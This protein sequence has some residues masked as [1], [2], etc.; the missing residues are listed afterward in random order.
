MTANPVRAFSTSFLLVVGLVVPTLAQQEGQTPPGA[1]PSSPLIVEKDAAGVALRLE[2]GAP[3]HHTMNDVINERL[4]DVQGS[5]VRLVVWEEVSPTGS[6]TPFQAISLD[7]QN[8]M[9]VRPTSY[10]LKV[11]HSDFDPKAAVPPVDTALLADATTNMYIVQFVT[12]P[13]DEFRAAIKRLGGTVYY[14]IA[15]N[16]HLVKM[17]PAVRDK[18]ATLPYVRWVGHYHPAYRIEEYMRENRTR[19]AELF[20]LQRYNVQVFE[21]GMAQKEAVAGRIEKLGG[22]IDRT[23]AGKYLLEATL[24]PEQ[25]FEVIRW[26]EV[27]FVDRWS[28]YSED[29]DIVRSIGG[30]DYI[31]TVAGYTGQGVRGEAYDAGCNVNHPDFASRPLILHGSVGV[32]AHGTATAGVCF[33]DGAGDPQARGLMPDGQGI[34]ADYN[35]IGMGGTNRYDHAGELLE[36]PY[37]AV[38]QTS[39]VGSSQT[40]EYTTI[41]A[42]TDAMLFDFD[43][44]HC[45]SQSNMGSRSSRPQAW[46]K[47]IVSGGAVKHYNTPT[48]DDDCWCGGASIGPA[49]DGRI[50]P[51]LCFFYDDTYTTYS[52]GSGYGE[53]GGTSGATP[54]ICGHIGLF[55]QMWSDG[56]FNNEVYPVGTG[57]T[58]YDVFD[59]RPHMTLA[60]A[61]MINTASPYD[62]SGTGHDLTRVHQGWGLP[63]LQYIYDIRDKLSF[64]NETEILQNMES[65][66]YAAYVELGEPQLRVTLVYADPE[67]LPPSSQ[68]RINDLTLKVTSPSAEVYWGNWGLLEGN[69]SVPGG[70]PNQVDTVENVFVGF[71]ESGAWTV[72]I[73]ASEINGDGHVETPEWDA[74]FSLVVT[75]GLLVA[76][77]EIAFPEGVPVLLPPGQPTDITVQILEGDEEYVQDS[78]MLHYRYD[79]GA[80]A[81][82]P[83]APLGGDLY[84]AT[85]PAPACGDTPEF[86]FSAEGSESGVVY[87]PPDAPAATF[88]AD[89]GVYV[90]IM[91]DDFET[92]QG[93]TVEDA[94]GLT[95]GTWER[96][97]PIGSGDRQDPPTD[98][99]GSGQCYLTDNE[100]GNSDVDDGP[101]MLLSPTIDLS[102]AM[103]PVFTYAR[104][105]RNDDQDEDPMDVEISDDD[106][107][108]WTLIERVVYGEEDPVEDWVERT[109]HV[110]DYIMPLTS[111]MKI[112][113]SVKDVPNNSINEAGIDAIRFDD[114]YCGEVACNMRGDLTGDGTVDGA[115]IQAFSDCHIGGDPGA[116]SC[117]CADIDE[118]GAFEAADVSEFVTCLLETVCP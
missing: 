46:A 14:F 87:Q 37:Y 44:I 30:A 111:Q 104:W 26:D 43:I 41:S 90:L 93:W 92:D 91:E 21:A 112:R 70:S 66:E 16:A 95:S 29:M 45:Q 99:D 36:D 96:G 75:G 28:P 34:V 98:Y 59:N 10:V 48:R 22:T 110:K 103:N 20:P 73:I 113:F 8:M 85:L 86:Y 27:L 42:D 9:T 60:K 31:E 88:T 68:Q 106:G 52:S 19:A 89:V 81:A 64:I 117:I 84:R 77:V 57:P 102:S 13:L 32:D 17:S 3:F 23:H 25:L 4:I 76:D 114:I 80:Y 72:E 50:K 63:D 109:I 11:R 58:G 100:D 105:W 35:V 38:F 7:G 47:N 24:T 65:V 61:V 54:S 39:S 5:P 40:T 108:S 118:S 101:T 107:A 115:D 82:V 69:W 83:L 74:D 2:T 6:V 71:P 1:T 56:I 97:V 51:D 33:G 53:F 79:G 62:F 94:P 49:S 55:H 18:V 12:Q 78:A 15:N 67:G 116:P